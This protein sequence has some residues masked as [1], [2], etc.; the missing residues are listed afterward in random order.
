MEAAIWVVEVLVFRKFTM[1][2]LSLEQREGTSYALAPAG[3]RVLA[4]CCCPHTVSLPFTM[5]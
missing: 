3:F 1:A 5:T 2:T 4:S